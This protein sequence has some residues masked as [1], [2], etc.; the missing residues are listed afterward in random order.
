MRASEADVEV[1][2]VRVKVR[3]LWSNGTKAVLFVTLLSSCKEQQGKASTNRLALGSCRKEVER[4]A[5]LSRKGGEVSPLV[6]VFIQ[7]G[8]GAIIALC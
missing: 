4:D 8:T 3:D 2:T 5:S 1:A 6:R 7:I